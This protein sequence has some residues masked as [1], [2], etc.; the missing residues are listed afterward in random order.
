MY[1]PKGLEVLSQSIGGSL[2]VRGRHFVLS[3]IAQHRS[4]ICLWSI[5]RLSSFAMTVEMPANPESSKV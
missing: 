4:E 5:D 2:I 3:S 1:L